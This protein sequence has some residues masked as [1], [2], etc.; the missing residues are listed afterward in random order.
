MSHL[1]RTP[2]AYAN[3][4]VTRRNPS[5]ENTKWPWCSPLTGPGEQALCRRR[6]P[7][8]GLLASCWSSRTH[9]RA[10]GYKFSSSGQGDEER[11]RR[12]AICQDTVYSA[13]AVQGTMPCPRYLASPQQPLISH[14]LAPVSQGHATEFSFPAWVLL[15]LKLIRSEP[16]RRSWRAW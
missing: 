9:T 10:P 1:A 4:W 7:W 3:T 15:P 14:L 6:F 8:Q 13:L 5:L 2:S 12:S 11:R 16:H